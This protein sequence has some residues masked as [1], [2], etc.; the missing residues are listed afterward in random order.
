MNSKHNQGNKLSTITGVFFPD[1]HY[2]L[3]NSRPLPTGIYFPEH[4]VVNILHTYTH[5]RHSSLRP[6]Q[7]YT[8]K[9]DKIKAGR[10]IVYQPWLTLLVIGAMEESCWL[11]Q[12][13]QH[14]GV[15]HQPQ[16]P[17]RS[18]AIAIGW[19][20]V[21]QVDEVQPRQTGATAG[22]TSGGGCGN[23]YCNGGY[24]MRRIMRGYAGNRLSRRAQA[25]DG[26]IN[27]TNGRTSA[28]CS[29]KELP[30]KECEYLHPSQGPSCDPEPEII[31]LP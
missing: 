20:Y 18:L 16:P 28:V 21:E 4:S 9:I 17:R 15:G 19:C 11:V 14:H 27:T 22:A 5:S 25:W 1:H 7:P 13:A 30:R 3:V 6:K 29:V 12:T 24:S 26:G 31:H 10:L 2:S 8:A 23:L